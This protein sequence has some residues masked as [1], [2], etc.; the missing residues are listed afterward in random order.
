MPV[1]RPLVGIA[2]LFIAGMAAALAW[3][4]T[5]AGASLAVAALL[6][7]AGAAVR[8][9][10]VSTP[11]LQAAVLAAGLA[12]GLLATPGRPALDIRRCLTR[13]REQ[14][15]AV[16]SAAGA[17]SRLPSFR[18]DRETW[19]FEGRVEALRHTGPGWRTATGRVRV[20]LALASGMPPP[21]YGDRWRMSAVC[22]VDPMRGD[23]AM[24][25]AAGAA[26]RLATGGGSPLLRWCYA[27]REASRRLL[28]RG[29][30]D[31]PAGAGVVAALVLG[32]R[33]D[34]PE[35]VRESF[36]RTG[37]GHIFAI[38]GL[39]VGILC[40]VLLAVLRTAG[41]PR[42]AWALGLI[43]LLTLYTLA[44]GAASSAVRALLMASAYWA[45]PL[46]RRRPDVPSALALAALAILAVRPDQLTDPGFLFSFVAVAGLVALAPVVHRP[47]AAWIPA[48]E[49]DASATRAVR[50]GRAVA[51]W[52]V[53]LVATSAAAWLVSTPL[54]A[55]FGNQVA[56]AALPGNLLVVPGSFLIVLTGCLSLVTGQVSGVAAEIFNHANAAFCAAMTGPIDA[57]FRLPGSH[58]FVQAPPGWAL[59]LTYGAIVGLLVLRGRPRAVLAGAVAAVGIAGAVRAATDDRVRVI[60]P[61]PDLAPAVLVDGPGGGDLL[62]DPGPAWKS[63]RTIR[64]LRSRGVDRLGAVWLTAADAAHAGAAPEILA[65]IPV[66]AIRRTADPGRSRMVR[67]MVDEW[68]AAGRDVGLLAAGGG[69]V[70]PGGAAW[71]AFHPD[72]R[73]AHARAS[74]G[75][76]VVR[77]GRG[78]QAVLLAGPA[79]APVCAALATGP[80]DPGATAVIID[81]EPGAGDTAWIAATFAS[82]VVVR[83]PPD[84]FH[85]ILGLAA[86]VPAGVR[87][88]RPDAEWI[89]DLR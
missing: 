56:V 60:L 12:H 58:A 10:A 43:P 4:G 79:A 34:I 19:T 18:D 9:T 49:T 57:L 33:E 47:L 51:R 45:A 1:R 30:E 37:T 3:P 78:S 77:I 71:D 7:A 39:H 16:V 8:H 5:P 63:A 84:G 88:E 50:A 75:A 64:W 65:R 24:D 28:S 53:G 22:G 89:L 62:I 76:A 81:R 73:G 2:L 44:T 61:P 13:P 31:W 74:D 85:S 52:A 11:L 80:F 82:R 23:L 87:V 86:A 41:L 59:A 42:P 36:M 15:D 67:A 55:F 25:V 32:Y 66:G 26:E 14:V 20:R 38:S 29:V 35:A 6:V 54:S 21:A 27:R 46:V 68:T 40:L 83:P 48:R 70:L 17:P 72:P 69:G